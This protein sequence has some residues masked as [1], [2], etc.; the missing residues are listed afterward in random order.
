MENR[1]NGEV[2]RAKEAEKGLHE[3]IVAETERATQAENS[4][5]T[6][7]DEEVARATSREDEIDNQLVDTSKSPFTMSIASGKDAPNIVIPSKDNLDSHAIKIVLD[8]NFGEI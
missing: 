4:L 5:S 2:E 8:S 1:L 6:R 3:E 7:I